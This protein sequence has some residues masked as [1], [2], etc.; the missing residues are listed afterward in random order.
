M[1]DLISSAA[2][3]LSNTVGIVATGSALIACAACSLR[4]FCGFYE[5]RSKHGDKDFK[6][7]SPRGYAKPESSKDS[8]VLSSFFK[9]ERKSW[10][11]SC[12]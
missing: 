7:Y 4:K 5:F 10:R 6:S 8:K 9:R 2:S 1:S 3:N 11:K 12:R